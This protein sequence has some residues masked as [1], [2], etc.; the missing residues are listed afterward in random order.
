MEDRLFIA[1]V[2]G[3]MGGFALGFAMKPAI[4]RVDALLAALIK[5]TD[6]AQ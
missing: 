1:W 4:D 5:A 3:L 6:I 2:L